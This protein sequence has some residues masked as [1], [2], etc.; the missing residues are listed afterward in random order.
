MHRILIVDDDV[1]LLQTMRRM[2][3]AGGQYEVKMEDSGR[4]ALALAATF[5]PALIVLDMNMPEMGG[6]EFLRQIS[7]PEGRLQYPVLVLT[8]RANM[9]QFFDSIAVDG[10]L[11][12]PCDPEEFRREVSRIVLLRSSAESG[13]APEPQ[14]HAAS[15][16][17][18][19][20]EDDAAVRCRLADAFGRAGYAVDCVAAGPQ[21][22]E[23]AIVQRPDLIL[24]K[25]ILA[26]LDGDAVA[27]TLKELPN[28]RDIPVVLYNPEPGPVNEAKF[29]AP[30][31]G[32]TRYVKSDNPRDLLPAVAEVLAG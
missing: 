12:K 11:S 28:T 29:T 13:P 18:L 14:V 21:V 25:L 23:K 15:R 19:I 7:T 2:L 32:I 26:N 30:Q 16:R 31:S 1:R 6:V 5:H 3:E 20:G 10:F 4:R 22:L 27:R 8:S 9:A 17:I 24:V